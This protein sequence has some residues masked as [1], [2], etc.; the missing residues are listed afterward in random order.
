MKNLSWIQTDIMAL[1]KA[2]YLIIRCGGVDNAF[3]YASNELQALRKRLGKET[4]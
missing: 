3:T 4:A 1:I 2:V